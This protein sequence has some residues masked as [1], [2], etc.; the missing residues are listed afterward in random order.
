MEHE[1]II[2]QADKTVLKFSGL[3]VKGMN[4]H[5]LEQLLSEKLN[6]FVRVIGVTGES[7]EMD[8]YQAAPE[9]IQKNEEGLIQVLSLAEGITATDVTKMSCNKKII[10]VDFNVAAGMPSSN[11][12]KERWLKFKK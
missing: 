9:Q 10:D 12:P 1:F 11:C 2:A 6:T 5:Q 3:K 4:T 8:V 7:I